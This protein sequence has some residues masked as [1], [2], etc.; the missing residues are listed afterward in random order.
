MNVRA[1]KFKNLFSKLFWPPAYLLIIILF[2]CNITGDIPLRHL[3]YR[4]HPLPES[5][6]P[7]VWD[8]GSLSD[9]VEFKYSSQIIDRA[10]SHYFHISSVCV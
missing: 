5:M 8:F 1:A 10:V 4:V 2:C 6:K 9:Q 7:L 3:V